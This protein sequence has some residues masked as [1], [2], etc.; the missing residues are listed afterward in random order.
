MKQVLHI[1]AKDVRRF[2]PEIL[3][4]LAITTAL[5]C[6]VSHL[7][8]LPMRTHWIS[9]EDD[10]REGKLRALTS[11]ITLLLP[12]SWWLLIARVIYA[13]SL[14]GDRQY[15]LTRPYDW[16]KL[17]G[18]KMTFIA[19]FVYLPLV[20]AQGVMLSAVGLNPFASIPGMLFNLLLITGVFVLPVVAIATV[21]SSFFRMT[22]TLLCVLIGVGAMAA[23]SSGNS[24]N[25]FYSESLDGVFYQLR[26]YLSPAHLL[27]SGNQLSLALLLLAVCSIAIV[28]YTLRRTWLSRLVLLGAPVVLCVVVFAFP[29]RALSDQAEMNRD[30]PPPTA[31]TP[32]PVQIS[33]GRDDHHPLIRHRDSPW[34]NFV[35]VKVPLHLSPIPEGTAIVSDDLEVTVT[36]ASGV[37]WSGKVLDLYPKEFLPSSSNVSGHWPEQSRRADFKMPLDVYDR[38][39][40]GPVNLHLTLALTELKATQVI[41]IPFPTHDVFVSGVGVCGPNVVGAGNI[42]CR[43]A[44]REPH[45]TYVSAEWSFTPCPTSQ[46][47]VGEVRGPTWAGL[48]YSEPAE[49]GITPIMSSWVDFMPDHNN[50][51]GGEYL[52]T[53]TPITFSQYKP[54]R[55]TQASLTIRNLDLS[56][57]Q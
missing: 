27:P 15:W 34:D 45:F 39:K 21:T 1:F 3:V 53:G 44:F 36:N 48:V 22:L 26:T 30:F 41:R 54:V 19:A 8:S 56:E 52:C 35:W 14:V 50:P 31:G 24:N 32:A 17:L 5:V 29:H 43:S 16:K 47:A 6:A 40:S 4:S 13:E 57:Q 51:T 49:L 46:T 28:Q 33:D 12:V 18:A 9:P 42:R 7:Y 23:H 55:R 2:W 38:L 11:L 25:G 20:L 37:S 10:A